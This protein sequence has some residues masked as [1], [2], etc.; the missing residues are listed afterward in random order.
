MKD[1]R[2]WS[3]SVEAG[4]SDSSALVRSLTCKWPDP[5]CHMI[6][7]NYRLIEGISHTLNE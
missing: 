4:H 3:G 5:E 7:I 1:L 6:V 2:L